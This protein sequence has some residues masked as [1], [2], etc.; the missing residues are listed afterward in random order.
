MRRITIPVLL[1]VAGTVLA[2][3]GG[4]DHGSSMG[5]MTDSGGAEK[6]APVVSS[7]R[8]ITV[9]GDAYTFTPKRIQIGAVEDVTIAITATDLPHD[10]TVEGVGHVAHAERGKTARGGL[11]IAKPG[12]YTFYCSVRGHRAEGMTGTLIVS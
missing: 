4:S 12:T 2:A 10:F 7:A 5:S 6:N 1:I 11:K 8:E 3:C 9:G